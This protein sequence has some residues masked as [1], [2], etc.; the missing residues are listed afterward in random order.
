MVIK[1]NSRP[2]LLQRNAYPIIFVTL[3]LTTASVIP[4]AW[5]DDVN[6]G[7]YSSNSKP[8]GLTY[9]EWTAKYWQWVMAIPQNNNPITDQSGKNCAVNQNDTHVFF[10]A[11][12]T[13]GS[14]QRVCTVP[15]DKAILVPI[16]N[17]V[18]SFAEYPKYKTE[19]E[20]RNCPITGENGGTVQ[21]TV[22]GQ[23]IL[24]LDGYRVQSPLFNVTFADH[25]IFGAP[26]G[27]TQAVSDGW[28]IFLQ[29]LAPGKHEIHF[30]GVLAA[31][32]ATGTQSF[33]NDVTYNLLVQ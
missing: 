28:W 26:S 15:S 6:P 1:G 25:N 27:K 11:G 18:C 13:V 33:A 22:D 32:P 7:V 3:S 8:Y 10:L 12:T 30:N 9:G 16:L 4:F 29:P 19:S 20:L 24:N 17:D 31:N 5:A 23:S 21:G 14:A 2:R